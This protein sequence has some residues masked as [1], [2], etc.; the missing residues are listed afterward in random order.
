MGSVNHHRH[1]L[2]QSR[3]AQCAAALRSYIYQHPNTVPAEVAEAFLRHGKR[4]FE[5]HLQRMVDRKHQYD[6]R[7]GVPEHIKQMGRN[8]FA[9][10]LHRYLERKRHR[11]AVAKRQADRAARRITRRA[12]V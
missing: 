8:M 11:R 10:F 6:P 4:P 7:R 2:R 9:G 12:A 1:Q 3:R 5:E